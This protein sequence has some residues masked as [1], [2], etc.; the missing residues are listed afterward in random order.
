M[1]Q[2]LSSFTYNAGTDLDESLRNRS[3]F[4]LQVVR[5]IKRNL[6]DEFPV[7]YRL[8]LREWVPGGIDLGEAIAFA[9]LLEREG[10]AYLSASAATFNS[11]LSPQVRKH[12]AQSAYLRADVA[13]LS[14]A[15]HIPTIAAGR[16][17]TPAMAND[18]IEKGVSQLVGLGRTLRVD[19]Q[20]VTKAR[21]GQKII[22]CVNCNMCLK[23]VVLDK[24][25]NCSRWPTRIQEQTELQIKL[26]SRNYKGL[27][28]AAN[29]RDVRLIQSALPHVLPDRRYTKSIIAP[30]LL[31]LK[32][33]KKD[34]LFDQSTDDF[35]GEVRRNPVR[36]DFKDPII[37]RVVVETKTPYDRAVN[38]QARDGGHG[39]IFLP[40]SNH[41]SWRRRVV[42]KEKGKIV[43]CIGSDVKW[44]RVLV[45]VDMSMNT[46]LTLM[47]FKQTFAHQVGIS[48]EFVHIL[49]GPSRPIE[50]RWSTIKALVQIDKDL[51]LRLINMQSNVAADLVKLIRNE[52]FDIIVI[53]RRGVSM[54]KRWMLGSV[55]AA[56]L[57]SFTDRVLILVD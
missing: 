45:P 36:S 54:V 38:Q 40:L 18:L 56:L 13:K 50:K 49:A 17:L 1:C 47:F 37:H 30:T 43:V 46:L 8:I 57:Q 15:V 10:V 16:I 5:E 3:I 39:L 44:R 53:G 34:T 6:P 41:E 27:L 21:S 9:K 26:L 4:P 55:S 23:R 24:G 2:F 29:A 22:P 7:G 35:F 48:P 14:K 11:M 28:V 52:G 32:S 31:I 25:Y 42:F 33:Q 51:P 20:W 12:M 19:S